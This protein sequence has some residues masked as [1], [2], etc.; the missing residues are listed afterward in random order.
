MAGP[1]TAAVEIVQIPAE[2]I[3]AGRIPEELQ[4]WRAS[5][6][7]AASAPAGSR[8]R[9]AAIRHAREN[10]IPFFGICLGCNAR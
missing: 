8:A 7:P 9:S 1:P 4:P 3:E 2:E 10:G 6:F 5:W